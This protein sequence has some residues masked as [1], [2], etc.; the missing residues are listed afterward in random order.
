MMATS[1]ARSWRQATH[2]A[3]EPSRLACRCE[4]RY[5]ADT[6][7]EYIASLPHAGACATPVSTKSRANCSPKLVQEA[8]GHR[9]ERTQ[10]AAGEHLMTQT[11]PWP[12]QAAS[13]ISVQQ[14]EP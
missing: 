6:H 2:M 8:G 9:G 13:S 10:L 3:D 7:A 4:L 14:S 5:R 12:K 1:C 11:A